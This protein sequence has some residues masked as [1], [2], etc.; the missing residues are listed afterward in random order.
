MPNE[1]LKKLHSAVSAEYELP[2]L[3]VFEQDMQDDG[4]RKNFYEAVASSY[5]LP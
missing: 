5:D 3:S 1:N 4:K 2:E